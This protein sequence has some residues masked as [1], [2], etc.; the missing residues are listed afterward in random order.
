MLDGRTNHQSKRIWAWYCQESSPKN[1]AWYWEYFLTNLYRKVIITDGHR[2]KSSDRITLMCIIEKVTA[3]GYRPAVRRN[4]YRIIPSAEALATLR[5]M[6]ARWDRERQTE[7]MS[8]LSRWNWQWVYTFPCQKFAL[9]VSPFTLPVSPFI[10]WPPLWCWNS[11]W[12]HT[13]R[14]QKNFALFVPTLSNGASRATSDRR[15]KT[16]WSNPAQ[17]WIVLPIEKMNQINTK[18][19]WK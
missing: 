4:T 8:P 13:F 19:Y 10:K 11:Q 7:V 9:F 12:V 18:N 6:R 1:I 5:V 16:N 3:I 14:C 2:K 17:S 15:P